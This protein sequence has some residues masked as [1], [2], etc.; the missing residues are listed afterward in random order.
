MIKLNGILDIASAEGKEMLL[1][2]DFSCCFMSSHRN[3]SDCKQLNLLFR[4]LNIKQLID[5]P[6]GDCVTNTNIR[7]YN[8][9]ERDLLEHAMRGYSDYMS[10]T[11]RNQRWTR[12]KYFRIGCQLDR[13]T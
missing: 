4:S 11:V 12:S 9:F 1:F 5:Q 13:V 10:M 2:G 6:V 3:D 8:Y 7:R